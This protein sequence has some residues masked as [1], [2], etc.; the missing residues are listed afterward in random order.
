M[1]TPYIEKETPARD[2][3]ARARVI[4]M[5]DQRR[6]LENR[7][8]AL[9]HSVVEMAV[10]GQRDAE[11]VAGVLQVVKDKPDFCTVLRAPAE[12]PQD[13]EGIRKDLL[14]LEKLDRRFFPNLA[15]RGYGGLLIPKPFP[16]ENWPIVGLPGLRKNA[17]VARMRQEFPVEVYGVDLNAEVRS[18][19][20]AVSRPYVALVRA[21]VE[22]DEEF[23]G[24]SAEDT[25]LAQMPCI[26]LME[27]LRLELFYWARTGQH[28]DVVNVTRCDGSRDSDG[29]VPLV[30]CPGGGV[31]VRWFPPQDV[32]AY[33]RARAVSSVA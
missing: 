25:V 9:G 28:L 33:I 18:D 12:A 24:R 3:R 20:A 5:T 10:G 15:G 22:A 27:R 30:G 8:Y 29:D 1:A 7:C 6:A 23:A 2:D 17:L 19:R 26:T 21:N 32:D 31:C 11:K 4:V 16:G 14:E 13:T